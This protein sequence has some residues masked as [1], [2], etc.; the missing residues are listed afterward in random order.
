[1]F[2][3]LKISI[4]CNFVEQFENASEVHRILVEA[5]DGYAIGRTQRATS[6][7]INLKAMILT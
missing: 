4:F 7:S 6:G 1:M 2:S 5:Y 3:C